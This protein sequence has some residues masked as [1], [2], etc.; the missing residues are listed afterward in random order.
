MNKKPSKI[1]KNRSEFPYG[2][3]VTINGWN[4]NDFRWVNRNKA[5]AFLGIVQNP[6]HHDGIEAEEIDKEMESYVTF[7]LSS[8]YK[9]LDTDIMNTMSG[10]Y[11][12][13]CLH[14]IAFPPKVQKLIRY[15][16]KHDPMRH[17]V[18]E[19]AKWKFSNHTNLCLGCVPP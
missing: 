10:K 14:T 19:N 6:S 18:K 11:K 16:G 3:I 17:F 12:D 9:W 5:P 1:L 8:H 15:R 7:A 13:G 2:S 4:M